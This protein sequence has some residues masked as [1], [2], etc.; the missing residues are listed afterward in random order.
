MEFGREWWPKGWC[1]GPDN[2]PGSMS[3]HG[4]LIA[5]SIIIPQAC[6]CFLTSVGLDTKRRLAL[7][8]VVEADT[9][10]NGTSVSQKR[11]ITNSLSRDMSRLYR[12]MTPSFPLDM[13]YR[14]AHL[15][16]RPGVCIRNRDAK[17]AGFDGAW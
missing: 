4:I 3:L 17:P 2:P 9:A 6:P 16:L 12:R 15:R 14:L 11:V 10:E 13:S 7:A 8:W 1:L 5:L